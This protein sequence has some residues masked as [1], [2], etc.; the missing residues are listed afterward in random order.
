M[1]KRETDFAQDDLGMARRALW[2]LA[3][4]PPGPEQPSGDPDLGALPSYTG[5]K[6]FTAPLAHFALIRFHDAQRAS[7]ATAPTATTGDAPNPEVAEAMARIG[8]QFEACAAERKANEQLREGKLRLENAVLLWRE[9]SEKR[10][11]DYSGIAIECLTGE[12]HVV[13]ARLLA[14]EQTV[15]RALG[16]MDRSMRRLGPPDRR[17][18]FPSLLGL[19][20][21]ERNRLLNAQALRLKEA[22][23]TLEEIAYVMGWNSGTPEQGKDRTRKR[24]EV[25]RL[26]ES[27]QNDPEDGAQPS[28]AEIPGY[29]QSSLAFSAP[30]S[31]RLGACQYQSVPSR[32]SS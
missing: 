24:L 12:R 13:L 21:A 28:E 23:H 11:D 26:E 27:D 16:L 25:A 2:L 31:V 10:A 1:T 9:A 4:H 19:P 15:E 5:A 7:G 30:P 18:W 3:G 22:D 8:M 20:K 32:N 14:A 6:G 17:D 29:P